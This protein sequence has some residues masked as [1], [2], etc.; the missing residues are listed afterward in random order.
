[1]SGL[2]QKFA[3]FPHRENLCREFESLFFRFNY[4][5]IMKILEKIQ[6]IFNQYELKP[7]ELPEGCKNL[8]DYLRVNPE[9][10]KNYKS[11]IDDVD[12]NKKYRK[13]I[14][15]GWYGFDIGTPIIP[16]WVEII[17]KIVEVCTTADPDFEIHQ[18]KLKFGGIRFYT[19]SDII[20]DLFDVERLIEHNLFDRALIY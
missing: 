18:I 17:D 19:G 14:P 7:I 5:H 10:G 13:H 8:Y 20:E 3:K 11:E 4:Q 9:E 2:N 12:L 1:M 6:E 16:I 15:K